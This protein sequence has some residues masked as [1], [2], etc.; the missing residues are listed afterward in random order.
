MTN[1]LRCNELLRANSLIINP[2]FSLRHY[3]LRNPDTFVGFLGVAF[4]GNMY[5]LVQYARVSIQSS[6]VILCA[7]AVLQ[8]CYNHL[9]GTLLQSLAMSSRLPMFCGIIGLVDTLPAPF[10]PSLLSSGCP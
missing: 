2:S 3:L 9:H 7:D 1:W 10:L 8:S 6:E 5:Q 4:T